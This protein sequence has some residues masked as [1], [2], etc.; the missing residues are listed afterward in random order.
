MFSWFSISSISIFYEFS[1]SARIEMVITVCCYF[2]YWDFYI[3]G[4]FY[5]MCFPV[6]RY[7]FKEFEFIWINYYYRNSVKCINLESTYLLLKCTRLKF[8][9]IHAIDFILISFSFYNKTYISNL[10][11]LYSVLWTYLVLA[12][13]YFDRFRLIQFTLQPL[14]WNSG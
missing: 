5:D 2:W 11:N 12:L 7:I 10:Y 8:I 14:F 6:I 1:I 9:I 3:F 13:S 4:Y